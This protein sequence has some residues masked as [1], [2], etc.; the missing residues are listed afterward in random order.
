MLEGIDLYDACR[1][2]IKEA[3]PEHCIYVLSNE[4]GTGIVS[5]YKVFA[6][7]EVLYNDIHMKCCTGESQEI[8]KNVI[9]INHCKS[10]RYECTYGKNKCCCISDGDMS[11]GS[12]ISKK[13][14][15]SFPLKAYHGITLVIDLDG[16]SDE[17]LGTMQTLGI[18]IE[19]IKKYICVENNYCV[20]R[21]NKSV[22]HIFSEL[23]DVRENRKAGY[24]K[25][26][27]LEL[28]LFLS[29]IDTYIEKI[30]TTYHN[31]DRVELVKKIKSYITEDITKHYTIGQL[32]ECFGVSEATIKKCFK[33]VYGMT[34]YSYLRH[35]RLQVS[36][37][38]LRDRD[39]SITDIALGIGYENPNKYTS[40][41]KEVYGMTPSE[42]RKK[43][44]AQFN[45]K[46]FLDRKYLFG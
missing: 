20:M 29:D 40:S 30:N 37:G 10:G 38:M 23:Y 45:H 6:G 2:D 34:I 42:F 17:I 11:I 35:Y 12:L 16:L 14:E 3:G 22:E 1:E 36:R 28:L 33:E 41:F 27:V 46:S 4:T 15:S 7:I 5:S 26:K 32:S 43:M 24:M 21:A 13:S 44:L 18:D 25:I 9:E 39:R 8:H 31:S 19:R